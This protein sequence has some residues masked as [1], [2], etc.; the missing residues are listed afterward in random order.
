MKE[1]DQP[2]KKQKKNIW[3]G[4]SVPFFWTFFFAMEQRVVLTK[5]CKDGQTFS[6][7]DFNK[8]VTVSQTSPV[9]NAKSSQQHMRES[10][11]EVIAV[12]DL[13]MHT[14][15]EKVSAF[16]LKLQTYNN[17]FLKWK[18]SYFASSQFFSELFNVSLFINFS[19][20]STYAVCSFW[21]KALRYLVHL[22][23]F[24]YGVN[25]I[26]VKQNKITNEKGNKK[27][28]FHSQT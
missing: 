3:E 11:P 12:L 1:D 14:K 13:T 23:L 21:L 27:C 17:L 18:R 2:V 6:L 25:N 19:L 28:F 24:Q 10:P 20:V 26:D 8:D 7:F 5:F 4:K 9:D 15:H 22:S 16:L